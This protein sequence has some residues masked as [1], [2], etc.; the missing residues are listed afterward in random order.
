VKTPG[1]SFCRHRDRDLRDGPTANYPASSDF[2]DLTRSP[3]SQRG[4]GRRA[5]RGAARQRRISSSL[6]APTIV[7]EALTIASGID[8]YTNDQIRVE[9]LP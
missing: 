2:R 4:S 9:T 5:D 7:K 3:T 6:D 1:P 8:I